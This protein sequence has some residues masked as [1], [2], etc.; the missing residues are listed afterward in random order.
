MYINQNTDKGRQPSVSNKHIKRIVSFKLHG[1]LGHIGRSTFL[2]LFRLVWFR[3]RIFLYEGFTSKWTYIYMVV[4]WSHYIG[5]I[6][7]QEMWISQ[8][9]YSG[10]T[11]RLKRHQQLYHHRRH[12]KR[13]RSPLWNRLCE[14]E[15][16]KIKLSINKSFGL[17]FRRIA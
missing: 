5:K 7:I 16:L 14:H 12:Q 17:Q 4:S 11:G 15:R 9:L 8:I 6:T 13:Y 10:L 1:T 3:I 2:R